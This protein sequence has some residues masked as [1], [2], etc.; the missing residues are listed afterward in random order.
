MIMTRMVALVSPQYSQTYWRKDCICTK[1][2]SIPS[3]HSNSQSQDVDNF[4]DA[5]E[6]EGPNQN[7]ME[8]D[9]DTKQNKKW[10][11]NDDDPMWWLKFIKF[12]CNTYFRK[13]NVSLDITFCYKWTGLCVKKYDTSKISD[14]FAI[15][16]LLYLRISILG[17]ALD[18]WNVYPGSFSY[19]AYSILI[20]IYWLSMGR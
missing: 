14:F 3:I 1:D 13:N 5:A 7:L 9:R 16:V 11:R 8:I 10:G 12:F 19:L 2:K 20:S 4:N 18:S 6:K 17:L 15:V